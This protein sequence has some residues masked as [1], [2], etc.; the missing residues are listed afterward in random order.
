MWPQK[1]LGAWQK[2]VLTELH[3]LSLYIYIHLIVEEN[4]FIVTY[5]SV[6]LVPHFW[7]LSRNTRLTFQWLAAA[8]SVFTRLVEIE[9]S[10]DPCSGLTLDGHAIII[11]VTCFLFD[12]V[13]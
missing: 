13:H 8:I 1:T 9:K 6:V 4:V 3:V 10:R 2:L 7:G 11:Q 12:S 5:N